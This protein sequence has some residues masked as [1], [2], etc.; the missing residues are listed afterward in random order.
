MDKNTTVA[1]SIYISSF[2]DY[3]DIWAPFFTRFF[4]YWK[5]C[6]YP[7]Y[8]GSVSKEYP[9]PRV[10]PLHAGNHRNWS[11]RAVEHLRQLDSRY[12]L[13]MLEDYMIDR[14]VNQ[15]DIAR[16]IE[17][18]DLFDLHAV[19]LFPDP[20]PVTGMPGVPQLGFQGQG[21]LNR[22]NT[23]ATIWRRESLLEIIRPG[24]S[25]WEF[26]S[27]GSIRSNRFNGGI[28]GCWKPAVHYVMAVGKGRWFRRGLRSLR[29]DGI[30]P[31]LTLRRAETRSEEIRA[32]LEASAGAVV[33]ALLPLHRRQRLKM[34]VSPGAYRR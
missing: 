29:R 9:D 20:P 32:W 10:V 26:E 14:P 12:V 4:K 1:L 18:M 28:C 16:V 23:H 22:T 27:N 31:D 34:W 33:R 13:M 19:R 7:I 30:F 8:L 2:D 17:W 6:A 15:A 3:S 11:S 24:E 21:Q 25:L 5:D